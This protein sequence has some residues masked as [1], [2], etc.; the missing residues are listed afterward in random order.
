MT[1]KSSTATEDTHSD[2][3]KKRKISALIC[4]DSRSHNRRAGN[5]D[6]HWLL[7]KVPAPRLL[8]RGFSHPQS[9]R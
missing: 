1:V 8:D 3:L 6:S 7:S 9:A 4:I 2:Y 5:E